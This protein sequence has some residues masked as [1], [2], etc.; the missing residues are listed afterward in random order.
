MKNLKAYL[1]FISLN[2]KQDLISRHE[3]LIRFFLDAA[4]S[5]TLFSF[6]I[7]YTQKFQS[8]NGW[9]IHEIAVLYATTHM[10]MGWLT[11]FGIGSLDIVRSYLSN[12][13]SKELSDPGFSMLRLISHGVSFRGFSSLILGFTYFAYSTTGQQPIDYLSL[14][15][16]SAIGALIMTLFFCVLNSWIIRVIEGQVLADQV[17]EVTLLFMMYPKTLFSGMVSFICLSVI[18]V[19]WMVHYP[20]EFILQPSL[21]GFLKLL[22][23]VGV[24]LI[25]AKWS[26]SSMK[27]F[28]I[29]RG[30]YS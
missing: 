13:V 14:L 23:A 22:L 20:A 24:G 18:P 16:M 21:I 30:D 29:E 8:I 6:W 28:V 1:Y 10:V 25:L 19:F 3:F 7:I 27:S 2:W 4:N 9:T 12:Q 11:L 26:L 15:L 17:Y 5:L